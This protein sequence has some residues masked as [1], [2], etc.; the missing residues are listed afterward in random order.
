MA[1]GPPRVVVTRPAAQAGDWVRRLRAAGVA[2]VALPLVEIAPAADAEAVAAAWAGLAGR[3]LAVFVSP[4]AVQHFFTARPAT[5]AWPEAL[6]AAAPGPGTADALRAAGVAP[7]RIVAPA[8]DAAQLDSEALWQQLQHRD[9]HGA[10]VLVVRGDGGR[11]WLAERLGEAGA[12]VEAVSAYRR[13]VPTFSAAERVSLD[14]LAGATETVWLFTS[15]QAVDHLEA[16]AGA[17]RW[18]GA[19]AI[20]THPRIVTRARAAGF[21]RVDLSAPG[22]DALLAC[23]QSMRP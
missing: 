13:A 11:E 2:A 3:R 22:L 10:R 9:W 19:R 12:E 4:N 5:C 15:S 16:A 6:V 20:A 14:A 8:D 21:S 23:I 7:D 17:G 18:Q 1:G